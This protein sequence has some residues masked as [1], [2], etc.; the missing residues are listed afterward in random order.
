MD[1]FAREGLKLNTE[2]DSLNITGLILARGG[3]KGIPKKN[4]AF[5]K[6]KTLLRRAIMTMKE[7]GGSKCYYNPL[8]P[9][10]PVVR[11]LL[12]SFMKR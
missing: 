6:G 2:E 9:L 1:P 8:Q 10:L 5:F 11:A 4:L 7:F 12:S 3:S